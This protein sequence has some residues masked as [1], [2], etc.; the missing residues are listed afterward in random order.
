[1]P[2]QGLEIWLLISKPGFLVLYG[3]LD[4]AEIQ[5]PVCQNKVSMMRVRFRQET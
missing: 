4:Y 1:M 5:I 3:C 2:E